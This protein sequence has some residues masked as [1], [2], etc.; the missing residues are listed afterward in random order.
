MADLVSSVAFNRDSDGNYQ[1]GIG[2]TAMLTVKT[3]NGRTYVDVRDFYFK[4]PTGKWSPTKRGVTLTLDEWSSVCEAAAEINQKANELLG[5]T[6]SASRDFTLTPLLTVSVMRAISYH[7]PIRITIAKKSKNTDDTGTD[8]VRTI[9]LK[10][11]CWD[12]M[13]IS[14][15]RKEIDT[16]ISLLERESSLADAQRFKR[17]APTIDTS[18]FSSSINLTEL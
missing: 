10:Q 14:A 18:L 7:N 17:S 2:G 9:E 8:Q 15:S 6:T 11:V 5:L 1:A 4:K 16:V 13:M 12:R 3:F